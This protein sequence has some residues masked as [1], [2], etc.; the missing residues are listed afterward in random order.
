ML[1]NGRCVR[2]ACI[3]STY[4]TLSRLVSWFVP[5]ILLYADPSSAPAHLVKRAEE[6]NLHARKPLTKEEHEAKL[7]AAEQRRLAA[8][9]KKKEAARAREERIKAAQARAAAIKAAGGPSQDTVPQEE[10]P[11]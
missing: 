6:K 1:S 8:L 10:V 11:K 5:L 3:F 2:G 9:D 7:K 4:G